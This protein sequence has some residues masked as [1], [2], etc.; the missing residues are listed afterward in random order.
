MRGYP[1]TTVTDLGFRSRDNFRNTPDFITHTFL[2]RSDY[3]PNKTFAAKPV[4]LLKASLPLGK[5]FIAGFKETGTGHFYA[6]LVIIS[7]SSSSYTDRE[8]WK[9]TA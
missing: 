4:Q 7:K 8:S 3:A 6:R 5:A 1:N 9:R 2:G